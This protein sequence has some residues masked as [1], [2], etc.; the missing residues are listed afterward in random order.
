MTRTVYPMSGNQ[1]NLIRRLV[2]ERVLTLETTTSL[3]ALRTAYTHGEATFAQAKV[4]ITALLAAKRKQGA[5][6]GG[7]ALPGFY[8]R[9]LPRHPED[10]PEFEAIQVVANRAG[11]HTYAK[12]WTGTSWEY[13]PGVGKTLAGLEPMTGDQAAALGLA[14]GRCIKCAKVLGG[15]TLSAKVSALIGYGETCAGHQGWVYPKGAEAQRA[16]IAE[17]GA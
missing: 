9:E 16:Y 8:V 11:T 6:Q 12:R 14:S 13:A 1:A 15:D 5:S 17:R 4:V 3:E 7:V 10:R 2:A